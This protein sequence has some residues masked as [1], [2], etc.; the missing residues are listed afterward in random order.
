MVY[1]MRKKSV[2][3]YDQYNQLPLLK[4]QFPWFGEVYS[5]TIQEV[6]DRLEKTYQNFFRGGGFPKFSKKGEYNSFTF[7]RS[8]KVNTK[9][10]KLPKIGEI[11]YFN[12]RQI[13]GIP[14]TATIVKELGGWYI[15]ITAEYE[16]TENTNLENQ[17]V[18]IDVGIA[19]F[20]TLSN[21]DVIDT[22]LFLESSLKE[23][24]ILNRRLSRQNKGSNSRIKTVIKLQKLYK[25]IANQRKDFLHKES[26]K[27]ANAY[28]ACY[29]EDLKL[30]KMTTLNS[31][32]TRR[33]ADSGFYML[34][35]FLQYKFKERG[36]HLGLVNPAYTSQ[37]CNS[38]GSVDKKSRLSQSEFVCTSCGNIDNSDLNAAKNILRV[39]ALLRKQNVSQ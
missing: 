7:K 5:D 12:S 4:Q 29:M 10:I 6:L 15:C 39:G 30:Q 3:K 20:A 32:L 25:K 26:T 11:K 34:R 1:E 18:G 8:F 22:P 33:M 17:E 21:S 19:H 9:T 35:T 2:S 38:C 36:N 31:T 16:S 37:T 28:T 23:L 14:K 13:I 24:R 27:I